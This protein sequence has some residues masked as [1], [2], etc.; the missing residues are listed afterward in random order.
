LSEVNGP[1]SERLR[2]GD[3]ASLY[4]LCFGRVAGVA[5]ETGLSEAAVLRDKCR[6]IK[7]LR[8]EAGELLE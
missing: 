3:L 6:I 5:A 7:R 1:G 2:A 8:E 4:A